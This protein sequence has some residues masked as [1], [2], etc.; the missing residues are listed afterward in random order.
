MTRIAIM[1][2]TDS[3]LPAG[4]AAQY[5]IRQVPINIHFDQ[6]TLQTARDIDDA[7]L[8]E[9]VDRDRQLPT[10][11]APTPGQF[12]EAYQAVLEG[13][14]EHI[15]CFCVSSEISATY[16]AAMLA[17]DQVSGADITVVDSRTLS[18]AQG[19]MVLA[20]AEAAR[21]GA[22]KEDVL[23]RAAAVGERT[24]L[25]AALPTLKYLAM[26]GRVGHL[27]AGMASLLNIKPILTVREGKLDMLERVRTRRKAWARVVE[28]VGG[29]LGGGS[30]ER[31]CILHVCAEEQAHQFEAQLRE[32][33]PCPQEA[34]L[35]ELTPGLSVHAGAG[36]VGVVFVAKT[37]GLA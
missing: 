1:T 27:A 20:A 7:G 3:S 32:G 29:T 2:D 12:I 34:I 24:H 35:A 11:S 4:L 28:L 30:M 5:G 10:T 14:S 33:V 26:S 15:V 31:M 8:F 19:F 9:R 13:G 6:E 23:A 36:L 17:A 22:S 16:Q 25:Y 21:A 37:V 18:M